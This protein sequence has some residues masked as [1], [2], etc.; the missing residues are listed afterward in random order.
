MGV[1]ANPRS[2]RVTI[3]KER[4]RNVFQFHTVC[5][6]VLA[7]GA[8]W[9]SPH[10]GFAA[11]RRKVSYCKCYSSKAKGLLAIRSHDISQHPM[12]QITTHEIFIGK[13][14]GYRISLLR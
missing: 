12:V 4:K 3:L 2:G 1:S 13:K 11:L 10:V 6:S 8:L 9:V 7:V 5:I 14:P